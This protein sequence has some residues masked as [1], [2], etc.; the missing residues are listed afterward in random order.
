ME[1]RV[2]LIEQQAKYEETMRKMVVSAPMPQSP[3]PNVFEKPAVASSY[4]AHLATDEKALSE[5]TLVSVYGEGKNL[6]GELFY[7]GGRMTVKKGDT[8]PGDWR[9]ASI[10]QSR[11]M[12]VKG[13]RRFEIGLGSPQSSAGAAAQV[14][15]DSNMH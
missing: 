7:R 3:Q 5:M 13:K 10:E 2:K 4:D 12:A 9:V 15:F 8:L 14:P 6:A 11:L 1:A